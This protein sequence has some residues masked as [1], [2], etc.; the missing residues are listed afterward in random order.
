MSRRSKNIGYRGEKRAAQALQK[1][2][3]QANRDDVP[4][5]HPTADLAHTGTTTVQVK[6]RKT[7]NVKDVLLHMQKH[8]GGSE[9]WVVIYSDSDQRRKDVPL[10]LFAILPL[11]E[12]VRL[13]KENNDE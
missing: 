6:C 10:G 8:M 7:W 2:W 3:P 9:D 5:M 12:Y 13:R 1:L 11:S 4:K